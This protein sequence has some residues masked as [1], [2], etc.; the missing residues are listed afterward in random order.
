MKVAIVNNQA[1]FMRG[2]AE[3][4][5]EWLGSALEERGH[6]A[7]IVRVPFCWNPPER[8]PEHMLAARLFRVPRAERVIAFKFPAYYIRHE[9]K[10][11]WLLHQFRQA[12][13][14]RGTTYDHIGDSP[15]GEGLI[16]LIK[17]ADSEYLRDAD[18]IYTNS[19][20][21]GD[22][23]RKFNQ[24]GSTVLY[25]PLWRED[26]Y[27]CESFEDFV[28]C[29]GRITRS[30]RQH[31]LVEA[32][33]HV[34]SDV[35]LV[36]AGPPDAQDDVRRLDEAVQRHHLGKR[37]TVIAK[38]ISREDKLDLFARA[39]ACAYIPVDEDSYG[40]VSLESLQARK[41]VVT[42]TDAGGI[43]EIVEDGVSGYVVPPSAEALA[44]A[45]DR[46]RDNPRNAEVLGAGGFELVSRLG[47]SWDNVVAALTA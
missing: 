32:M 23:L 8:I 45:F 14:L 40:Y 25:P 26:D 2:G 47:I 18:R 39:L 34:K 38:W 36:I 7:Q 21:T 9:S 46:L 28:F 27:R 22:R 44:A 24:I 12:Y 4:L 29:P 3:L 31:L 15:A 19:S 13:D 17:K 5:A 6:E 11:I 43:L 42:T 35:R 10:V 37:I 1:P 41:P 16:D 33:A 30:K 20:V